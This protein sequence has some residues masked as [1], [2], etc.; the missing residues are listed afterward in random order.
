MPEFTAQ[1]VAVHNS[2]KSCW[3]V[4]AGKVYDI[5]E[6]LVDHPGGEEVVL[7]HAGGDAT[8]AFEGTPRPPQRRVCGA[9]S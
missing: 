6:F 5:T 7:E 4:I 3:L 1:E 8:L 9:A 2:S